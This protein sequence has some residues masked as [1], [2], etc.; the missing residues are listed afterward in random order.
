MTYMTR[1]FSVRIRRQMACLVVMC[2]AIAGN[3]AGLNAAIYPR[4]ATPVALSTSSGSAVNVVD[5]NNN[6]IW[7]SNICSTP[8]CY[9]WFAF[10]LTAN[11][12]VDYVRLIAPLYGGFA[13][14]VPQSVNIY[15]VGP[16]T[17]GQ[18]SFLQTAGL[19]AS[20]SFPR[21]GQV[22]YLNAAVVA[23]GF[24]VTTSTPGPNLASGGYSFGLAEAYA[25]YSL[26]PSKSIAF[27]GFS[28]DV[29][30]DSPKRVLTNDDSNLAYDFNVTK[31]GA[32]SYVAVFHAEAQDQAPGS[33]GDSTAIRYASSPDSLF[34]TPQTAFLQ[35]EPGQTLGTKS[36]LALKMHRGTCMR[37]RSVP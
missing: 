6:T 23:S 12:T 11:Q 16:S 1:R 10:W 4:H 36:S 20:F 33:A 32:N 17:G 15:Y 14:A 24:L 27:S 19:E 26:S 21:S 9:E 5:G 28:C 7:M 30:A 22:I 18:W 8:T 3:Q 25:G 13:H 37:D 2:G 34:A 31:L 29:Y 35:R